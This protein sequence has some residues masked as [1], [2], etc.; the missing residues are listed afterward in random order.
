MFTSCLVRLGL[1][2]FPTHAVFVFFLLHANGALAQSA[3][4]SSDYPWHA[5]AEQ[6]VEADAK[7]LRDARFNLDAQKTYSLPELVD[8]AEQH[9]PETRFAWE[10]AR[11]SA[12][13]LGIAR[14]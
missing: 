11:A 10:Q 14:S 9:N 8:L 4:A 2:R 1:A 5:P 7:Q 13:T 3:P 12:A 6:K